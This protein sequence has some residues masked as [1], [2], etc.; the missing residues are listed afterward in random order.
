MMNKLCLKEKIGD[1]AFKIN[2][3]LNIRVEK[4]GFRV[5]NYHSITNDVVEGDDYQM[6]TPKQLFDKQMEHLSKNEYNVLSYDNIAGKIAQRE[7]LPERTVCVTFDDG[8]KDNASN[9]MPILQ[10]YGFKATIFLTVDFIA[11]GKKW[12]DWNDIA[13]LKKT[14]IFSF[15]SHSVSHRKLSGL[16]MDELKEEIGVS[17]K[18]LEDHLKIPIFLFAYPF[19]SYGSFDKRA[20]EALRREGYKAA[21][22]TV[23]GF[24]SINQDPYT[25]RRTRISWV[26]DEYEFVKELNGAYDW[27]RLWQMIQEIR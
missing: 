3:F 24:N 11:S 21:F 22:T 5:L 23:A 14:G 17:K 15:G 6:T 2:P 12:L 16:S 18:I 27:Y 13:E 26:D 8:F 7:G 20:V 19:G 4:N 10:K 25:I 1:F 9:A